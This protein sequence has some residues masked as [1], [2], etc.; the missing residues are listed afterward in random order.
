VHPTSISF[1]VHC[2]DFF[3]RPD[4]LDRHY[5]RRLPRAATM[6]AQPHLRSSAGRLGT[7]TKSLRRGWRTTRRKQVAEIVKEVYPEPSKRGNWQRNWI[8]ERRFEI[9]KVAQIPL[10]HIISATCFLSSIPRSYRDRTRTCGAMD[11]FRA[12]FGFAVMYCLVVYV[13]VFTSLC[14]YTG[15]YWPL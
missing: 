3:A 7:S 5:K 1:C 11:G 4:L 13:L 14:L 15:R 12:C 2:D 8:H 6:S 9:L 10:V